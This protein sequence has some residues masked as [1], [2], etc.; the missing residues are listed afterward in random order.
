M[1]QKL[2]HSEQGHM[3]SYHVFISGSTGPPYPQVP[4]PQIQTAPDGKQLILCCMGMGSHHESIW[5][6][7]EDVRSSHTNRASSCNALEHRR[8]VIYSRGPGTFLIGTEEPARKLRVVKISWR[9]ALSIVT[10]Q[11]S[12]PEQ[13]F[14]FLKSIFNTHVH[15]H[16]HTHH[17]CAHNTHVCMHVWMRV[18][19]H[20]QTHMGTHTHAIMFWCWDWNLMLL[21]YSIRVTQVWAHRCRGG[22]VEGRGQCLE[23]FFFHCDLPGLKPGR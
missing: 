16:M 8:I 20:F 2:C 21:F 4:R 12:H 1:T 13:Y 17:T 3:S 5:S 22:C 18:R 23:S 19:I 6:L 14:S 10:Q 9:I 11:P 7:Q 15:I